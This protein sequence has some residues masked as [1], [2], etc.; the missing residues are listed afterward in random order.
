MIEGESATVSRSGGRL[1]A[2]RAVAAAY[3]VVILALIGHFG[4]YLSYALRAVRFP[5]QLDYGEG[6]IW[7]QAQMIPGQLMYGDITRLP[8]IVFHYPPLYHL[9]V[10][11]ITFASGDMLETGRAVSLFS[12]VLIAGLVAALAHDVIGAQSGRAVRRTGAAI[13]GL[14]V[15]CYY[16]V[17]FWSP[18][19]RVDM[20][21]TALSVLGVWLFGR[22]LR[23]HWLLHVAVMTFVLA[24]YTKQSSIAAPLSVLLVSLLVDWR[25][26]LI[27]H[28]LGCL[29]GVTVLLVLTGMTNGGFLRHLVVYNLNRFSFAAVASEAYRNITP[30]A[31]FLIMAIGGI[32]AGWRGASA[33][34]GEGHPM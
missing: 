15:F 18:Y 14:S 27:A 26:A 31:I 2:S 10:R 34:S 30:H 21:A 17:V 3:A 7:Q 25:R 8:F 5:F 28:G 29:I 9:V 22:S 1:S 16:P 11:A 33:R 20:L 13:A 19:M 23:H 4:I 6:I 12:T 24:V 32:A